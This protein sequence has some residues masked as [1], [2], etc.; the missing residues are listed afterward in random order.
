MCALK[1]RGMSAVC[2][3]GVRG[4][5]F[6]TLKLFVLFYHGAVRCFVFLRMYRMYNF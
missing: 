5:F 3:W 2:T 4:I 1:S 6:L